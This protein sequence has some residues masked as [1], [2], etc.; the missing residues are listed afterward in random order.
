MNYA[1]VPDRLCM[2]HGFVVFVE[3]KR[4]GN[5][6]TKNQALEL[7]KI[8]SYG[9]MAFVVDSKEAVDRLIEIIKRRL[10]DGH[11]NEPERSE[12]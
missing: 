10:E 5:V 7:A 9:H 2:F 1:S 12:N 8:S 4:P 6:P 3:C 11:I